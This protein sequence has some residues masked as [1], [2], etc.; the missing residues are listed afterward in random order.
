VEITSVEKSGKDKKRYSVYID[1]CYSFSI[2][3][4]DYISMGLYGKKEITAR[5][6]NI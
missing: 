2:S 5:K 3:E 1:N 6:L 4:E